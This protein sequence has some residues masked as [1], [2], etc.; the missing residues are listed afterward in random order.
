MFQLQSWWGFSIASST[1]TIARQAGLI[2]M[3]KVFGIDVCEGIFTKGFQVLEKNKVKLLVLR[4]KGLDQNESV[5]GDFLGVT[6]AVLPRSNS[7]D[8]RWS[9][10]K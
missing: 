5:I 2:S 10:D 9:A 4:M 7:G 3:K 1:R 8:E 6:N